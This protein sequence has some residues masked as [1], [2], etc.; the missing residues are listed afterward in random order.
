M[1]NKTTFVK[2]IKDR[3]YNDLFSAVNGYVKKYYRGLGI[4]SKYA[5]DVN[6]VDFDIIYIRI[7]DKPA[8]QIELEI[9]VSAEIEYPRYYM[10]GYES[11]SVE[12]WLSVSCVGDISKEL[13]DFKITF[14]KQHNGEKRFGVAMS[15]NL[16]PYIKAEEYDDV[17]SELLSYLG[18]D[19]NITEPAELNVY[20]F[21]DRAGLKVINRAITKDL[22]VFGELVLEDA[23]LEFYDPEKDKYIQENVAGSTIICDERALIEL[24]KGNIN[25]TIIHEIIHWAL[26]RKA[27]YLQKLFDKEIN[28]ISCRIS[29]SKIKE[30]VEDD[31]KWMER[32][33][34][35]I[36]PRILMPKKAFVR[37]TDE[38]INKQMFEKGTSLMVDV[39]Q[40]VIDEL[41]EF[42]NVSKISA[43]LRLIETGYDIAMSAYVYSDGKYVLPHDFRKGALKRNQTYTLSAQDAAINIRINKEIHDAFIAGK[44]KYVDSHICINNSK[45]IEKGIDGKET[46]TNYAR[47]NMHECCLVF[48]IAVRAGIDF[49]TSYETLCVFCRESGSSLKYDITYSRD[50]SKEVFDSLNSMAEVF[51]EEMWDIYKNLSPNFNEALKQLRAWR[52]YTQSYLAEQALI[53]EKTI[54]RLENKENASADL[55]TVVA[56][57]IGLALP[58]MLANKF[59]MTTGYNLQINNDKYIAYNFL[60]Q[61]SSGKSI[62]EC[63]EMLQKSF[64]LPPLT[65]K[66]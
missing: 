13:E 28:K 22:A 48:D 9:I 10:K 16:V 8:M 2:Y 12:K 34:N 47:L 1:S 29:S 61:H 50:G 11:A 33:A 30:E 7:Q 45:Y 15:N 41:A 23:T 52:G 26:H 4:S 43:K 31:K 5:E 64:G 24:N 36:T 53:S 55:E 27:F 20:E 49:G 59:I 46:L 51:K 65:G 21:A 37:K 6:L 14:V 58:P 39:I 32:Q 40:D 18:F 63:N 42:F 25:N 35:S 56:I 66:E 57:C 44:L 60:I 17:A 3:F 62:D 54:R 38:L 19:E